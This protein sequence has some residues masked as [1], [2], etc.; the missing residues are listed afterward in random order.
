MEPVLAANGIFTPIIQ[1]IAAAIGAGVVV[2]GFGGATFGV[3]HRLS[4]KQ[5]ESEA[6]RNSYIGAVAALAIWLLDQCIVYAT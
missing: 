1:S 4:R 5:V 2:G 3:A 6:L